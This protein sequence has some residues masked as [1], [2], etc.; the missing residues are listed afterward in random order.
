M[1][2]RTIPITRLISDM[3]FLKFIAVLFI[4]TLLL[5]SSCGSNV[6]EEP[7]EFG[8]DYFPL[9][10]GK[11]LEYD[12]DSTL[13]DIGSSNVIVYN[14]SIQVREE[15]TDS[16]P[17]NEGRIIYRIDRFERKDETEE[18]RIK[19]VWTAT[20]TDRQA[21]RVEENLRFIKLVFPVSEN[22]NPWN[23]NKYID[24]NLV[25]PIAGESVFVFKNWLYEYREIDGSLS[26]GTYNFD[27]VVTVYQADEE[28]FIELRRSYEQYAK[29]IGLIYREILILDT[30][31]IAP[32]MDDTW[33]EKAEKG[34]IVRQ[35]I[36][37]YN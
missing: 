24:E 33:E 4:P 16:F 10:I 13:Y 22:T 1:S 12:V 8:Y 21:E 37:E 28:N 36:R 9:E 30:Q 14:N 25:I 20:V 27:D 5:F 15:V 11:Y 34:F 3:N 6:V 35:T 32:C 29:G 31:C 26:V 19:D 23:G 17:D 7:I 2:F 18:W